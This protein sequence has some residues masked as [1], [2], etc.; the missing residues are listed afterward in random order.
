ME[1]VGEASAQPNWVSTRLSTN[2]MVL[3]SGVSIRR[4]EDISEVDEPG[5]LSRAARSMLNLTS[6]EVSGMPV[7]EGQVLVQRAGV[8]GRRT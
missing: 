4:S 6:L 7:V 5:T 8:A 3:S 1:A 2:R